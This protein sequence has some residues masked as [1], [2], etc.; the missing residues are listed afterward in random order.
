MIKKKPL[1]K[2]DMTQ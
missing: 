2:D 1:K